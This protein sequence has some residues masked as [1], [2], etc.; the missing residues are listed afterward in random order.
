MSLITRL[1]YKQYFTHIF[2]TKSS[3]FIRTLKNRVHMQFSESK[4]FCRC[5]L[6]IYLIFLLTG[7]LPDPSRLLS[8]DGDVWDEHGDWDERWFFHLRAFLLP[9]ARSI[10]G[11]CIDYCNS[12]LLGTSSRNFDRVQ[13]VLDSLAHLFAHFHLYRECKSLEMA[14]ITDS[15]MHPSDVAGTYHV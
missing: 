2:A 12:I 6:C 3:A 8:M 4:S 13:R 14:L 1:K 5:V 11:L 10:V 7:M 9:L 15:S